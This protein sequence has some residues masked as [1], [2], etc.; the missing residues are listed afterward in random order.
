MSM[1]M[2]M[3]QV[4][5]QFLQEFFI[6]PVQV[7]AESG[8]ADAERA[9]HNFSTAQVR[10]DTPSLMWKSSSRPRKVLVVRTISNSSRRRRIAPF[11][12]EIK[13]SEMLLEWTTE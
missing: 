6:L 4:V 5:T 12:G 8:F 11:L 3:E 9:I 10:K 2:T 1:S 7:T 13:E